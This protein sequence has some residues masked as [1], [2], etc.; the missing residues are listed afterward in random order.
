MRGAAALHEYALAAWPQGISSSGCA[1][2][3]SASCSGDSSSAGA[4]TAIQPIEE[5][6]FGVA[7]TRRGNRGHGRL[8]LRNAALARQKQAVK[9]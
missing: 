4:P 5:Q 8:I 9:S 1:A 3:I 2:E 6:V 7:L